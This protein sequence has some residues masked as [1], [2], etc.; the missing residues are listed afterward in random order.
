MIST[1]TIEAV[2]SAARIE[3]IVGDFVQLSKNGTGLKAPCPFHNE[4]TASFSVSPTRNIYKCFGCGEGGT[5]ISFVMRYKG[6][7]YP[8]AIEYIAG[9][10]RIEVE[11]THE[12][13]DPKADE[14]TGVKTTLAAMQAHFAIPKQDD[15]G[16]AYFAG[17]GLTP[18][19]IDT[20][21]IGYCDGT[22]PA[23][24]TDD[25]IRATGLL[26]EKGN[27]TI[28]KRVTIPIHDQY[29]NIVSFAGRKTDGG[30][31]GAKYINGAETIAYA[32]ARTLYNLHRAAP[33]IRQT[34]EVW[35]VEGY[36]DVMAMWQAG[37]R[38]VVALCGTALTV[39]QVERLKKFNGTRPLSFVL[40]LDNEIN[41]GKA[42]YKEQVEKAYLSALEKFL[43]VGAVYIVEYPNK[44]K[45]MADVVNAGNKPGDLKR[46]D[47]IIDFVERRYSKEWKDNAS[48]V[49]KAAFQDQVSAMIATVEKDNT[50]DIYINQ[51]SNLLEINAKK[52]EAL[53]RGLRTKAENEERDREVSEYKFIKVGDNYYQRA[54]DY[55]VFTKTST[56]V[57]LRRQRAELVVEGV[58]I[59][60]IKRFTNWIIE[61]DHLG[62]R[63]VIDVYHDGE[64]FSFFNEYKPLPYRP[65]PFDL[66]EG[67]NKD[68]EGFDYEKIPEIRHTAKFFKHIGG[69]EKYGNQFVKIL[70]DWLAICY[71]TPSQRLPAIAL[72]S[73]EEGT[74][75]S[76]FINLMLAF[77]GQNATKTE[78]SRIGQNFNNMA[79]GK[80]LQC[81]EE[82]KDERG[83]I[84]NK[85]K[86]LIT[87]FEQVVEAKHQDARTVKNFS[88][89]I[90]ASNHEDSFMKVG[91]ATTRFFV[92]KVASIKEKVTDYESLLFREIPYLMH[93]LQIRKVLTPKDPADGRLWFH[94]K[95]LE[96]DALRKLR[97]ASKD[98]VQQVIEELFLYIFLRGEITDPVLYMSSSYLKILM[99]RYGGRA[100]TDKTPN[101]FSN[102]LERQ[103]SL[104]QYETPTK[105]DTIELVG[106]HADA[107]TNAGVWPWQYQK[108][109]ARFFEF[110][111]WRFVAPLDVHQSYD[112]NRVAKIIAEM[113]VYVETPAV[114]RYGKEPITWLEHL[115]GWYSTNSNHSPQNS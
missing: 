77:F 111:I 91:T 13:P 113:S 115:K 54:V 22:K 76:T 17:R 68:P 50:R 8:E 47:A 67:F 35:I 15:P 39:E 105:K 45:D 38:N 27:L 75:K 99:E 19:T 95:S 37:T 43:P 96:N 25:Q 82:T 51:L 78:A 1:N 84:E 114:K 81:V 104:Y 109:Q 42:G 10:Y 85:L 12:K 108:S 56:V 40:A 59:G 86:D 32:K 73:T 103:M 46:L 57:Y 107:W 48:P 34:G 112:V 83:E 36:A 30:T 26:N 41:K 69:F 74:G 2:T 60:A 33:H 29:G 14:K 4:K 87:S 31:D 98:Q 62:Y 66:P 5:P 79:A 18:E 102:V 6:M 28:Y 7:T 16:A 11:R 94:P 44:C 49:E 89:Y 93:F 70:W 92:L 58:S 72:V 110:P 3:E 80:I 100:Y 9:K 97:Q 64:K 52:L 65:K 53:V 71:L 61:P 106:I 24:L 21:G 88:K 23:L 90:F 101:Y 55:D 20:F 63:R